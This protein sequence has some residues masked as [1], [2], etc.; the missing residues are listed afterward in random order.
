[1]SEAVES[2]FSF[3][4]C[5]RQGVVAAPRLWEKM[6]TQILANVEAKLGKKKNGSLFR[7][8]RTKNTPDTQLHVG[9]Q[10][11]DHVPFRK[12]PGTDGSD[13]GS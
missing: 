7:I 6:A 4:R 3:N 13:S 9:L 5:L 10:L 2:K 8:G 11:L 1:M 12:S